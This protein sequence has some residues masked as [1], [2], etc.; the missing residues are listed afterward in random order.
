M[1]ARITR[2]EVAADKIAEAHEIADGA[3]PSIRRFPGLKAFT[4]LMRDDGKGLI[5]AVYENKAAA[6]AAA[7]L[8]RQYWAKFASVL[9]VAPRLQ[10]FS[11]VWA[12]ETFR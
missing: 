6:G 9:L 10:E 7:P 2:Y 8:V 11:S 4:N 12:L 1:Y 5:V 3:L